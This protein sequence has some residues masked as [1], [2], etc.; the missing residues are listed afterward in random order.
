MSDIKKLREKTKKLSVLFVDDEEKIRKMTGI[1]LNKFFGKVVVCEDGEEGI[2]AFKKDNKKFDIVITDIQMPKMD[3]IKM[4][5]KIK[6]IRS[7]IFIIFIT[8]SRGKYKKEDIF[9]DMYIKKPISY[10]DIKSIMKGINKRY[11]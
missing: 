11:D 2:E 3:G 10:E 6:K 8:A 4:V 9:G 7:D 1:L 5:K